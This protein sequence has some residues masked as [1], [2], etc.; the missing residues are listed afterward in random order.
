MSLKF[1]ICGAGSIGER[2]I[3]NLESLGYNDIIIFRKRNLPL[4]TIKKSYPTYGKLSDALNQKPDIAI[5]CNPTAFHFE[6]MIKCLKGGC[7]VFV[8][9]PVSHNFD[10]KDKVPEEFKNGNQK[11]MV[12]YMLRFHPCLLKMKSWLEENRIGKILYWRSFWGEFLPNWHPYEDYST[13]Y[14]AK[15]ELGGG[16]VL[17]LSHDLD[18][19]YWLFGMPIMT[20]SIKSNSSNLKIDTEHSADALFQFENGMTAN[21][22]LD[23]YQCPPK[24]TIEITG[25]LGRIEFDYYKGKAEIISENPAISDVYSSPLDFERNQMFIDEMKYFI[26]CIFENKIPSP[27]LNEGFQVLEMAYQVLDDK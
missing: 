23:F 24:R 26:D 10:S 2:H 25:E 20:K 19:L 21:V 11:I 13:S 27:D 22:H 18:T 12:G 15:S 5:I 9:K 14:A 7:H 16:P 3:R 4:R 6:T 1:L 8:E 17:T